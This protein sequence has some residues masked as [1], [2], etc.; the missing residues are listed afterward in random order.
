[1]KLRMHDRG[2]VKDFCSRRKRPYLK[3]KVLYL[4]AGIKIQVRWDCAGQADRSSRLKQ[5]IWL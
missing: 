2:K 5:D 1:M 3:K 4:L